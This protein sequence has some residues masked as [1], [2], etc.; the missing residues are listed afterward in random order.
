MSKISKSVFVVDDDPSVRKALER[1][2]IH[3]GFDVGS[4]AAV[5]DF[6]KVVSPETTGCL[7]LDV[8]MPGKSGLELQKYLGTVGC[9]LSII[10]VTADRCKKTEAKA[11]QMGAVAYLQKP[12]TQKQLMDSI[13]SICFETK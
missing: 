1:S 13:Q 9:K 10:F 11:V 4:F 8:H 2:L 6:L 3:F 7:I 12:F 5:E